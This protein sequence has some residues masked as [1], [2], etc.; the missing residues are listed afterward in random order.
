MITPE[1]GA[2]GL[3]EKIQTFYKVLQEPFVAREDEIKALTLAL[4]ARE[5]VIL[6]GEP[7]TAK[8]AIARRTAE[9]INANFFKYLLT[10]Y[11][12][13]SELFG[14]LDLNALK[15]G[16]YVRITKGKM[17]EAEIVFLDEVFNANSAI[18]NA[19]LSIMQERIWYDGYTEIRV[20]LW[21]LIGATNRVP[22]EPELEAVYDRF[23]V[24][25]YAKPVPENKWSELLDAG[26]R[27]E[28]G[29]IPPAEPVLDMDT[30]AQIHKLIFRVDLSPIKSKLLRLYAIFEERGIHLTDRRKTKALKV[31]AAHA[32]LEG[33][34]IAQEK[35]L[36][37]LKYVAPRDIED[38]EKVNIILSEELKMPER[39]IKELNDIRANVRETYHLVDTMRSYDPRLVDLFRSLKIAK[40][41]IVN[42][43]KETDNQSVKA[44]AE[45]TLE[46]IDKLLEKISY[47]LG[48]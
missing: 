44:L 26:W 20:P 17:P 28:S 10:K 6:I 24:R 37:A 19:L 11:T 46:E 5:H 33:R 35:D 30:L 36:V 40:S 27:I 3:I 8:S 47:K 22:E 42:I 1:R 25:Q 23:L 14:P 12:E 48:M 13:P 34:I 39:F 31:I 4:V 38:F 16:K 45:K 2:S 32:L 21:T 41:R 29:Q 9:L 18:L 15:E 43:L 7:G